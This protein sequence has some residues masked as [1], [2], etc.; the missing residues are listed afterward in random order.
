VL[1]GNLTIDG[2]SAGSGAATGI[3]SNAGKGSNGHSGFI[4]VDVA[5]K[6]SVL[7]GAQIASNSSSPSGYANEIDIKAGT[8]ELNGKA[9]VTSAALEGS[10]GETGILKISASKSITLSGLS[11]FS[12]QNEATVDDPGSVPLWYMN[13]S[14]PSITLKNSQINASSTG[15][16]GASEIRIN[17]TDRMTI[18]PSSITTSAVSGNGGM[19]SIE[20]TGPLTLDHS[21]ITT[22]VTGA[23]NGN[24]GNINI[25]APVLVLNTGFI[26]ANTLATAASGG[27]VNIKVNSTL[28]SGNALFVGGAPLIFDPDRSGFNVIQAAAPTGVSGNVQISS[29][30][31]D[32]TGS[33]SSLVAQVLDSTNLAADL[34]RAG[35][36]SSLTPLG[37]GGLPMSS[38]GWM[39]PGR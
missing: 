39:R 19:I 1:A 2:Q 20:G 28:S 13:V 12:I 5:D 36:G 27:D 3:F 25:T 18:D 34:C 7:N 6:L 31:I 9:S 26:Q 29:P 4:S 30:Q 37:H 21:R 22:S 16:V 24:G 8:I 32:L 10:S 14:A 23:T 15:N 33:L 11:T 38:S 35:E 17:Y